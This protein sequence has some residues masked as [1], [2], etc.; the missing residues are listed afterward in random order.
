V[1]FWGVFGNFACGIQGKA[2]EHPHYFRQPDDNAALN[3]GF[4]IRK[5]WP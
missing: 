1:H 3:C 4:V 5:K 2:L